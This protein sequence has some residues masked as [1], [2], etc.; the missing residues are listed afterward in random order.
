VLK[1]MPYAGLL[2]EIFSRVVTRPNLPYYDQVSDVIQRTV[3]GCLAG[4]QP[5]DAALRR[6]QSEIDHIE[7]IY[8]NEK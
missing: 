8:A 2:Q 3:N 4:K 6:M 5:P 1:K 7:G